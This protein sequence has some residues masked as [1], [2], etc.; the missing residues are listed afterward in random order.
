[1]SEEDFHL[2]VQAPF[3]A[4]IP[5]AEAGGYFK[6]CLFWFLVMICTFLS[7]H[8]DVLSIPIINSR[9]RQRERHERDIYGRVSRG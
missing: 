8:P 9:S 3:Q 7:L 1:M 6:S 4:H 2:S 5:P